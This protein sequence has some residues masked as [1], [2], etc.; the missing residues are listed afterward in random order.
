MNTQE[1]LAE[2]PLLWAIPPQLSRGQ[3]SA[4]FSSQLTCSTP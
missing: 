3:N 1:V 2:D 4:R